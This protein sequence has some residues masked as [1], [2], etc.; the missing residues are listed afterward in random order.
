MTQYI[1]IQPSLTLTRTDKV[2]LAVGA[3]VFTLFAALFFAKLTY[4]V[5]LIGM[6]LIGMDLI[7][8]AG[9]IAVHRKYQGASS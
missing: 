3:T 2:P 6:D 4:A 9:S 5:T 8:T 1:P 7:A